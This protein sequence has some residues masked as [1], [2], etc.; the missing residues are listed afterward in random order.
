ME[1]ET[2]DVKAI[3]SGLERNT[4]YTIKIIAVDYCGNKSE[5]S[6]ELKAITTFKL[7]SN[8]VVEGDLYIY[9][10]HTV[11]LN[12]YTLTVL[13]KVVYY[14]GGRLLIRNGTLIV[15]NDFI[16]EDAY[17]D[18]ES[19]I[20]E[21]KSLK[22]VVVTLPDGST[23]SFKENVNK[24]YTA[25]DS[26][27]TL[28]KN[29]NNH[30]VLTTKDSTT[31]EFNDKNYLIKVTDKYGNSMNL[32]VT[33]KGKVTLIKDTAGRNYSISYNSDNLI[34]SITD[35]L[36]NK[37]N[38]SYTDKKLTKVT[39]QNGNITQYE[40]GSNGLLSAIINS[41]NSKVAQITYYDNHGINANK[42]KAITDEYSN[43]KIY[44]YDMVRMKVTITD[45]NNRTTT[46]NFDSTYHLVGTTD[47]DGKI[48]TTIYFKDKDNLC[49]YGEVQ[50]TKDR[51]GNVTSYERDS[52]G[53]ITKVINP[54]RSFVTY[55]YDKKNNV[56]KER[57][58]DG[59]Y[60]YYIY[61]ED[62]IYLL[63]EVHPI[64]GID[65]YSSDNSKFV[66]NQYEYY[67]N[68]TSICSIKG[69]L[70]SEIDGNGNKNTY[71]YDKY[72]N[73]ISVT[74]GANNT[75]KYEYNIN[76]WQTKV[77]TPEGNTVKYDFDNKGNIIR[78]TY[79]D[80]LTTRIVYDSLD[81][82]IKE[83]SQ[84]Q[85][86]KS[87]DKSNKEYLGNYGT[88]Y[89]YYDNGELKAKIDNEGNKTSYT[90]DK[91]KNISIETQANGSQYKYEYDIINRLI[92]I[93][94][95]DN[96]KKQFVRTESIKYEILNNG[97]I[98]KTEMEYLDESGD[99]YAQV[100]KVNVIVL[101]KLNYTMCLQI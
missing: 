63:K 23:Q 13:G 20:A 56:I 22:T 27:N 73:R 17:L 70:K 31:Y 30:Y 97:N 8:E 2:T 18:L 19:G 76:G 10:K 64:N 29:S 101:K 92:G 69:L 61:D 32:T 7:E 90:Y 95:R 58:E 100:I 85:Y 78:T 15:H 45:S 84:N 62:G 83:I 68:G 6:D 21:N 16:I 28:S 48:N 51:N 14:E 81:N 50:S 74:N 72:G 99:N 52:R 25:M 88:R 36:N 46:Q 44:K 43:T 96:D 11:D 93:Y 89:E 4:E 35:P 24:T 1:Q 34:S 12:G 42:V 37:I 82:V 94:F 47:P 65:S 39:D 41:K 77:T 91:Y 49:K 54:D 5:Y 60:T 40:Y 3:L 67:K 33:D 9:S 53:N 75:T 98:Q 80:E 38:Y 79:N 26:R 57:N 66:I 71:D 87:D 86:V 55:E 59:N